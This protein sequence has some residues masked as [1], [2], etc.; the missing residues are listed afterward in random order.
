MVVVVAAAALLA[1][2]ISVF[3]PVGHSDLD[4]RVVAIMPFENRTGDPGRDWIGPT[5]SMLIEQALARTGLVEVRTFEV[6][7]PSDYHSQ[8]QVESES[9]SNRLVDFASEVGAGTVIH[10][11]FVM[12][13]GRIRLDALVTDLAS[14]TLLRSVGPV[15]GDSSVPM[16]VIEALQSEVMGAM[17]ME[18]DSALAPYVDQIVHPMTAE[19]AQEFA[20]GSRLFL[21][22]RAFEAAQKRLLLAHELDRGL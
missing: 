11:A 22:E 20:Q 13:G 6:T 16:D 18:F 8:A 14:G 7:F 2:G 4:P 15:M 5:T 9:D 1:W 10:G 21:V 12:S 17:A 19:A 3:K